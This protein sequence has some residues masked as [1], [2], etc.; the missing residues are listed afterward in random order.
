MDELTTCLR[1][2]DSS[3]ATERKKNAL[4]LEELLQTDKV[5]TALDASSDRRTEER[6][7][8][9]DTVFKAVNRYIEVEVA[10]LQSAKESVSAI[11]LNNRDKKKQGLAAA[12]RLV[13][14]TAN[15]RD[16]VRLRLDLIIDRVL[17]ILKDRYILVAVGTDFSNVL[18]KLVLQ[19]RQYWLELQPGQWKQLLFLYL[20]IYFE[21]LLDPVIVSRILQELISGSILQ[22][23]LYPRKLFSFF[24]KVFESIRELN[25]SVIESMLISLNLFCLH[26]APSCRVQLCHFG[27][28]LRNSFIY[29]W[30]HS[31]HEKIRE[32]LISFLHLLLRAHHP[33]GVSDQTDGA[34]AYNW[35]HW[36]VCFIICRSLWFETAEVVNCSLNFHLIGPI[37]IILSILSYLLMFKKHTRCL[38]TV[39]CVAEW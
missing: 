22:G 28:S 14:K 15:C 5:I 16:A 30:S 19:V 36:K 9:W 39:R 32:E 13:I 11:T 38:R 4:K 25:S 1:T 35:E 3:K 37:K 2:L 12:F 24:N 31:N 23:R 20:K 29:L 8:T 33:Y 10:A 21:Q 26:V 18:L 7:I 17:S 34:Y 6:N 27:E